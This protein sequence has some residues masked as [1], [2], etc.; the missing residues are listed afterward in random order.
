MHRSPAA[1]VMFSSKM[2]ANCVIQGTE[3][4]W[5]DSVIATI[6]DDKISL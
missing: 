1:S 2:L 4:A 6:T 3:I 5:R